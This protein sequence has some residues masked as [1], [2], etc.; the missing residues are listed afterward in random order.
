VNAVGL[1]GSTET[2]GVGTNVQFRAIALAH[3]LHHSPR[4]R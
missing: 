4:R 1:I 2:M 3:K